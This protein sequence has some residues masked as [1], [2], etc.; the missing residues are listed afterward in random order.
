MKWF[1]ALNEQGNQFESYARMVKVVVY[2][3]QKF[4]S[5]EPYFLY[6]GEPNFLREWLEKRNV[7]IIN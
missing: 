4:T 7:G 1:F 6:D 2:T 5:L 3:A